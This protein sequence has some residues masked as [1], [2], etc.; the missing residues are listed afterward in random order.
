MWQTDSS[1]PGIA[2]W[3]D[4]HG[5][6]SLD[7]NG[8]QDGIG[9][10]AGDLIAGNRG[11]D[12]FW[13]RITAVD[14]EV[15]PELDELFV[16]GDQLHLSY[17]QRDGL[18]A[19]R[20]ALQPIRSTPENLVLEVTVAIQTTLLDTHPKLDVVA[21]GGDIRDLSVETIAGAGGAPPVSVCEGAAT[22]AVILGPHDAP[23]T[24][25]HSTENEIRLRLFGDFLEK[26]VIRKARPWIVVDRG[27]EIG[28]SQ[29][30]RIWGELAQ[31]PLPLTP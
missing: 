23:F 11:S 20:L 1:K 19:L 24:T 18:F 28:D 12:P 22:V 8:G 17:P 27:R 6:W 9:A 15:L 7:A 30:R 10:V 26:G 31:S 3:S 29:L 2:V 4:K 14:D 13:F 16:R 25:N 21:A 5:S